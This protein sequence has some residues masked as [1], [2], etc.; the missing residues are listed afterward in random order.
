[1][2]QLHAGS[3]PGDT[4]HPDF[5]KPGFGL[6]FQSPSFTSCADE[7]TGLV[8]GSESPIFRPIYATPRQMRTAGHHHGTTGRKNCVRG[9]TC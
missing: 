9:Q 1:M 6:E 2:E 5:T 8:L 3:R 7:L 4:V